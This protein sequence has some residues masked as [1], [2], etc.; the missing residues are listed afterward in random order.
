LQD[1]LDQFRG[2]GTDPIIWS[3]YPF[4]RHRGPHLCGRTT[5]PPCLS[6]HGAV[7]F[8]LFYSI[9]TPSDVGHPVMSARSAR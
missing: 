3:I 5:E 1:R 8:H 4:W 6:C 7:P 2:H 9:I